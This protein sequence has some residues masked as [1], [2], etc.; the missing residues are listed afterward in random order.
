MTN[1]LTLLYVEDEQVVR[2]NFTEIF[3]LYF[4]NILTADNG[5]TALE[6]YEKNHIDVAILD[7]SIPKV[8]GLD[9]AA[10]IREKDR[11]IQIIILTAYSEKEKL[12]QAINLQ[13]FSYLVKPVKQI[14]LNRTLNQV[15]DKLQKTAVIDLKNGY[16]WDSVTELLLFNNE[17]VKLSKN[18]K[19]ILQFLCLNMNSHHSAC[20]IAEKLFKEI[21]TADSTCN[22]VVQLL[23]RFKKKMLSK[24]H[25][26][27]FFIDNIYGLG[28][29]IS[30]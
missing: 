1:D 28:Y 10:K 26:E 20:T 25:N 13:L 22:N 8:N 12:L 24:Y 4:K 2:E 7:I 19:K 14:E 23:S 30:S 18:E 27:Y 17:E 21:N 5:K 6:I 9:V 16:S 11:D 15:I 29:K 3:S